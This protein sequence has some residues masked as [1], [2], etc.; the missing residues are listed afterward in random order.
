MEARTLSAPKAQHRCDTEQSAAKCGGQ[1]W[2]VLLLVPRVQKLG[3]R[4]DQGPIDLRSG[5]R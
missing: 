4:W 1:P 3:A 2:T 5:R